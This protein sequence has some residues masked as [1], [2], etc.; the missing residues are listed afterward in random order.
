MSTYLSNIYQDLFEPYNE[1]FTVHRPPEQLGHLDKDQIDNYKYL[2]KFTMDMDIGEQPFKQVA[3]LY[4]NFKDNV[5]H[6]EMELDDIL[7]IDKEME[8]QL[9]F[10]ISKYPHGAIA[11]LGKDPEILGRAISK[12]DPTYQ[13]KVRQIKN[14]IEQQGM[15]GYPAMPMN[16]GSSQ[17]DLTNS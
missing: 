7:A 15:M 1:E 16:P 13:A 10:D 3:H 8:K 11:I 17:V 4:F 14:A 5:F 6:T 9:G 12:D 2:G